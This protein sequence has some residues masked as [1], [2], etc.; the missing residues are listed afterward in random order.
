M[1]FVARLVQA[2]PKL[3]HYPRIVGVARIS[4]IMTAMVKSP[5][6]QRPL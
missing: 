1:R 6:N 4:A 2:S 5:N 3:E